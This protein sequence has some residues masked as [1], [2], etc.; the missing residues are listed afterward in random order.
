M[1]SDQNRS[2]RRWLRAERAGHLERAEIALREVFRRLAD[3]SPSLGF[4]DVVMARLLP[5]PPREQIAVGWRALLA[6]SLV[7]VAF[8]VAVLPLVIWPIAEV[9]RL[10]SVIDFAASLVVATSQALAGWLSFWQ[11]L[12]E[13]NRVFFTIVSKPPVA[14]M[15]L[16]VAGL[17]A[18][19]IRILSGLR[20]LDRSVHDV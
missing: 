10:S 4:V 3:P 20:A 16:A 6:A 15:M 7:L 12:G 2:L 19:A 18:V 17:G 11:S 1:K 9:V 8:S 14:V 13:A 5:I